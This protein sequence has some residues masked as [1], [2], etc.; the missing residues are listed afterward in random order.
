M[1]MK[2]RHYFFT[3]IVTLVLIVI[4]IF[5]RKNLSSYQS[6]DNAYVRG[7][8]TS[9]SSRIEGYVSSVP[10]VVNTEVK[11]GDIIVKF[12]EA[13]FLSKVNT[14]RADL[15]AATAKLTEL[16]V[17]KASEKLKVEEKKL[18]LQL[19]KNKIESANF[20]KASEKSN[21]VMFENEKD[22]IEKLLKSNHATK[23]DYE[24]ALAMYEFSLHRVDQ[25]D[26]DI[27]SKK[28]AT[29]V[30]G[31]EIKKIEIN[32]KKLDA[33][34]SRYSAKKDSL[35]AKLETNLI[36]LESTNIRAPIDGIIANRIVEPGVYMKKGW[37]LMSVVPVKDVWVIANFK[38]TQIKNLQAGQ[39]AEIMIDAFSSTKIKGQVLSF[40]PA[41]ASSFSLIPP[42]NA[43]GNFVKVVQR[44]PIK[45]KI[46]I[47]SKLIGKIIPG[48]SARV[49]VFKN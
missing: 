37:P 41:S 22:R 45:I 11:K 2:N 7:S 43:S 17:L 30:I 32:L 47:P 4:I 44:I 16:E 33:E 9:I 19:A 14:A 34:K 1:L 31:K 38:E 39:R 13:P 3:F 46:D 49:K 24:K 35:E 5:L 8:I 10:G 27:K 36:D 23:S 6:T 21:L 48:L 42:Q 26:T 28:I 20:R 12:D 15:K 40:S 18:K 25:Y 29:Q